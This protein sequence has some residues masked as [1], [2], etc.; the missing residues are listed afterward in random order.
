MLARTFGEM[1]AEALELDVPE[2]D[3]AEDADD[4]RADL[5]LNYHGYD[6]GI[7]IETF[8]VPQYEL[9]SSVS[10]GVTLQII[11]LS[12]EDD[13]QLLSGYTTEDVDLLCVRLTRELRWCTIYATPTE[14]G[15]FITFKRSVRIDPDTDHTALA[16]IVQDILS[17][18]LMIQTVIKG[19]TEGDDDIEGL[20]ELA[21]SG[22]VAH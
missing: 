11:T 13:L 14:A 9:G 22:P 5:S 4:N 20:I 17:E 6:I 8:A 3:V 7:L 2:A 21:N 12:E 15:H 18:W 16:D 10:F 1:L 19:L